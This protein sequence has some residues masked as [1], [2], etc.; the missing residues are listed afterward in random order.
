MNYLSPSEFDTYGLEKTTPVAL[1]A[2]ASSLIDAHC[3]RTSLGV[4]LYTERQRVRPERNAFRLTFLPLTA[5]APATI[6][7]VSARGRF[8]SPRRGEELTLDPVL[9]QV[10]NAF[11]LPGAWT[12]IDPNTFDFDANTGEVTIPLQ[13]LGLAY[14]EVEVVYNAGYS[15]IPDP[16]KFACVQI[17]RNLQAAP[18]L[19]VSAEGLDTLRV[20]YFRDGLMDASVQSLLAPY[21]VQ[22][23]G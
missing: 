1:V 5:V 10:A 14:N 19:N 15:T 7:F 13:I 9:A 6:P 20:D 2:A 8:S 18:A 22:R 23:L 17:V 3:H 21:V 11:G 4:A 12:S 16:A